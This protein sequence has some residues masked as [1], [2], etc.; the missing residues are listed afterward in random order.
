MLLRLLVVITVCAAG[1][2]YAGTEPNLKQF[3]RYYSSH[4]QSFTGLEG[5]PSKDVKNL[6]PIDRQKAFLKLGSYYLNLVIKQD[7]KATRKNLRTA[8]R[9]SCVVAC[10]ETYSKAIRKNLRTASRNSCVVA[11]DEIYSKATRKN[12]RTA[13]GYLRRAI[14]LNGEQDT[15]SKAMLHLAMS[16]SLLGNDNAVFYYRR[17]QKFSRNEVVLY[18][19][20]AHAEHLYSKKKYRQAARLYKKSVA[21][22][23]HPSYPYSVYK[24]AWLYNNLSQNGYD[25]YHQKA[26]DSLKLLVRLT[27]KDSVYVSLQH[28]A[29]RALTSIW[30]NSPD[31]SLMAKSY[32]NA[33]KHRQYYYL[34]LENIARKFV[35]KK[36]FKQAVDAYKNLLSEALNAVESPRYL[37]AMLD[38]LRERKHYQDMAFYLRKAG[39]I[40]FS[41][42]SSWQSVNKSNP[43]RIYWM[44]YVED[45]I[46]KIGKDFYALGTQTANIG[47]YTHA[48]NAL[49][50]YLKIS[51]NNKNLMHAK[52]LLAEIL[53]EFKYYD[54]ATTYYHDV[55]MDHALDQELANLAGISAVKS[56]KKIIHEQ[57]SLH[58]SDES[59]RIATEKQLKKVILAYLDI[60]TNQHERG[61][62]LEVARI[63]LKHRNFHQAEQHLQTLIAKYSKSKETAVALSEHLLVLEKEQRWQAI[64]AWVDEHLK[65]QKNLMP[66]EVQGLVDAKY[67]LAR[68]NHGLNL[69]EDKK[70]TQAAPWLREYQKLFPDDEYADHV[71]LLA[72]KNFRQAGD[73]ESAIAMYKKLIENYPTSAWHHKA[74]KD[75]ALINENTGN[76]EAAAEYFYV[77]GRGKHQDSL[78]ALEKSMRLFAYLHLHAKAESVAKHI[79][80]NYQSLSS[81]FYRQ[82]SDLYFKM[83]EYDQVWR[84]YKER[85]I[86]TREPINSELIDVLQSKGEFDKIALMEKNLSQRSLTQDERHLLAKIKFT[87][88]QNLVDEFLLLE[89]SNF[90]DPDR[91]IKSMQNKMLTIVSA[92]TEVIN[93][94]DTDY[95]IKSLYTLGELYR[96]FSNIISHSLTLSDERDSGRTK[97]EKTALLLMEEAGKYYQAS[98]TQ[99]VSSKQFNASF[100]QAYDRMSRIDPNKYPANL[101]KSSEPLYF[102]H[103]F[104]L[105]KPISA[106]LNYSAY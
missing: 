24:L 74:V 79:V 106:L 99:A 85:L 7:S 5:R 69:H 98:Y 105:H 103:D 43:Q 89:L 62:L 63:E 13:V 50:E 9:N 20:L 25:Q 76:F 42:K 31:G 27:A 39:K 73:I 81:S 41:K 35:K 22:R 40:Y 65:Q 6:L 37:H 32:F 33:T 2:A 104:Y 100:L 18:A 67:K 46:Y 12:L 94:G 77:F 51:H 34:T 101:E 10:D 48:R 28:D 36:Q 72:G 16:Q 3:L 45:M 68:L 17:L 4:S 1:I 92:L 30:S 8:S 75:L 58:D 83:G 21:Y 88:I 54:Q 93:V 29:L 95:K 61:L 82:L 26:I 14:K 96:G 71:L 56:L 102:A 53:F 70:H 78:Q 86:Y 64:I 15:K 84:L 52:F 60:F 66:D 80:E 57:L 90:S 11:C 49:L 55:L 91:E 44:N 23:Q 38:L 47:M 19:T 59:T 97:A 87:R